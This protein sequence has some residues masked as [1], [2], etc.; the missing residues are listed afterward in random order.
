MLIHFLRT[1]DIKVFPSLAFS[2]MAMCSIVYGNTDYPQPLYSSCSIDEIIFISATECDPTT[3]TFDQTISIQFRHDG[4]VNQLHIAFQY[5]DL[6]ESPMTITLENLPS[7]GNMMPFNASLCIDDGGN[8]CGVESSFDFIIE[9]PPNCYSGNVVNDD[10][11]GAIELSIQ[12][13]CSDVHIFDN[14]G[15]TESSII[16]VLKQD[17]EFCPNSEFGNPF[18]QDVWFK[19]KVPGIK[20]LDITREVF[21]TFPRIRVFGGTCSNLV[22]LGCD[23]NEEDILPFD[24]LF[25]LVYDREGN[26]QGPF[27]LCVSSSCPDNELVSNEISDSTTYQVNE[28]I[29]ADCE[30][31]SGADVIFSA[32]QSISLLPGFT[33]NSNSSLEIRNEGCTTGVLGCNI[34]DSTFSESYQI[35]YI[36]D[37]IST[38]DN[39]RFIENNVVQLTREPL[40]SSVRIINNLIFYP[41]FAGLGIDLHIFFCDTTIVLEKTGLSAGCGDGEITIIGGQV[42]PYNSPSSYNPDDESEFFL[43]IVEMYEDDGGCDKEPKLHKFKLTKV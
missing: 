8:A 19:I 1:M 6:T 26:N 38:F 29:F 7:N 40:N 21:E 18:T 32:G 23:I 35:S 13:E 39:V 2:I 3:N 33:M 24:S 27:G 10:C 34:P 25:L 11:D 30:I 41:G 9:A 17:N 42:E 4:T 14:V 43:N 22:Y 12:S 5:F 31:L 37:S 36:G 16:D 20:D 15:A 28:T